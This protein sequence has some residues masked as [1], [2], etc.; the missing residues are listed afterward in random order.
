MDTKRCCGCGEDKPTLEFGRYCRS[1][2]GLKPRCKLCNRLWDKLALESNREGHRAK[3]RARWAK[4]REVLNQK[5]GAYRE[6]KKSQDLESYLARAKVYRLRFKERNPTK[7]TEYYKK[8][9]YAEGSTLRDR[10]RE[11]WRKHIALLSDTY[12]KGVLVKGTNLNPSNI[13]NELVEL[14]RIHLKIKRSIKNVNN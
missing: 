9:Y 12:I 11:R 6:L 2:D 14:K 4:N 7:A 13:P 5:Q 8:M 10:G 1:K 3:R